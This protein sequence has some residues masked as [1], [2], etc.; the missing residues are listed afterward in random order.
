[1][2]FGSAGTGFVS[3]FALNDS[4]VPDTKTQSDIAKF[5]DADLSARWGREE[6]KIGEEERMRDE[7]EVREEEVAVHAGRCTDDPGEF[8]RN[9]CAADWIVYIY[10]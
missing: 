2:C 3:A 8:W 6:K 7:K 10:L 9:G 1:M 4:E 5:V